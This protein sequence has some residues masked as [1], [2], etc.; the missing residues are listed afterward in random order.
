[1]TKLDKVICLESVYGLGET[2]DRDKGKAFGVKVI[3]VGQVND[4]RPFKVDE[5][6]LQQVVD[7][8]NS[9]NK[10]VKVRLTHP[11]GTG[12]G[13]HLGRA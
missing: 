10:R 7:L 2:T 1:M 3:Q 4:S 11:Q 6:T 12:R 9:P 13:S 8:G 5:E